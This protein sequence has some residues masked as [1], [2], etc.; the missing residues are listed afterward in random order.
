MFYFGK[1]PALPHQRENFPTVPLYQT[2]VH[3]LIVISATVFHTVFFFKAFNLSVPEHR[4]PRHCH[5][6]GAN[7]E[8]LIVTAE[9]RHGGLFI[10]IVHK[11]DI[12]L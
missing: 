11:I 7:T 2:G 3:L 5:Q 9:L 10:G 1:Q 6:H 4:Q 8:I 12:A